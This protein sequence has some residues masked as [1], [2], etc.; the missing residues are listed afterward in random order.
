MIDS[1]QALYQQ[2]AAELRAELTIPGLYPPNTYIGTE[3]TLST[4]FDVN[5]TTIGRALDILKRENLVV[6]KRSAGIFTSPLRVQ[7]T[8]ARSMLAAMDPHREHA[9]LGPWE[10]ALRDH[11][12]TGHG[13][14]HEVRHEQADPRVADLL[15][16]EVGTDLVVR[17]RNPTIDGIG[18]AQ[19]QRAF[20][21]YERIKDTALARTGD[22][23]G[24]VYA[25]MTT[26]GIH[27]AWFSE[28]VEARPGTE[29]ELTILDLPP[30]SW[31]MEAWRVT[32]NDKDEPIEALRIVAHPGLV[33]FAY[34]Q[35]LA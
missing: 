6:S 21:P 20:M 34:H 11:N 31:V 4:R 8:V 22:I 30:G 24:G 28:E 3:A 23:L 33:K 10:M 19:L 2:I 26:V 16:V 15:K 1:H 32:H 9:T 12:L 14:V 7:V 5:R 29:A 13:R 27:P 17:Y 35:A 18:P 25:Y